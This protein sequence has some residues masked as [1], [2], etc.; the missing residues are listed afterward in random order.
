LAPQRLLPL[1]PGLASLLPF[2]YLWFVFG[3][4]LAEP[5]SFV[6]FCLAVSV[7]SL[8]QSNGHLTVYFLQ[9]RDILLGC[10]PISILTI[11]RE[12]NEQH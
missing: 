6:V 10:W 12:Q 4:P 3:Q 7:A 8:I 1:W 11:D 2:V 9:V 5:M